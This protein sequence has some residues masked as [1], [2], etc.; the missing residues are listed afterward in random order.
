[1][2]AAPSPTDVTTIAAAATGAAAPLA[3]SPFSNDGRDDDDDDDDDEFA[4]STRPIEIVA[5]AVDAS[6]PVRVLR[7][8]GRAA[9]GGL[10]RPPRC[11]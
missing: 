2:P 10:F 8:A 7:R 6:S 11:A 1:L 3:T 4:L 9:A 5:P